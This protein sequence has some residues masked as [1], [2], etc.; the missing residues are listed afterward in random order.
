LFFIEQEK[1]VRLCT[2]R[3]KDSWPVC[4]YASW[5]MGR[6]RLWIIDSDW[7]PVSPDDRAAI[8]GNQTY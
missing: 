7:T 8:P 4:N 6:N 5:S 1:Y 2:P 3:L